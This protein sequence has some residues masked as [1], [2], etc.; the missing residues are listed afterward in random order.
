M[1]VTEILRG[2]GSWGVQLRQDTRQE[3]LDALTYFGHICINTGPVDPRTAGDAML[4]SARYVGIYRGRGNSGDQRTLIGP[5]LAAW[6]GDEDGKGEVFETGVVLNH[7]FQDAIPLLLPPGGSITAGTIFDVHPGSPFQWTARYI[8]PRE[9]IDYICQTVGADWRVNNNGTLDAGLESDLFTVV[10][11]AAIRRR[12]AGRD[13]FLKAMPG[14]LATDQDMN[15]FSTRVLLLA[16]GTEGSTVTATADIDPGLNPF[17][18]LHGNV[19]RMTRIVS[20]SS[21]DATN[22]DARAQL[23]LNRFSGPRTALTMSTKDYDVKGD[24]QVGDYLWAYDPDT[25]VYDLG[26][27]VVFR[28]ERFWPVALR[29]TEMTW[30]VVKGM[31]VAYRRGDGTWLDL[32]PYMKFEEGDTTLVVGGYNRNLGGDGGIAGGRPIPDTSIPAAPTWNETAFRYSVY[33]SP[34]DGNSKAQ[35][36]LNW[37]Q[38]LNVDGSIILDGDHYEIQYRTSAGPIFPATHD[39]MALRTHNQLALGTHDQPIVYAVSDVWETAFVPFDQLTY[40]LTNLATNMPYEAKIRAVDGAKP[41]NG[42]AWSTVALFQTSRDTIPPATPAPPSVAASKLAIQVTHDLGRSDGGTFNL[43]QDLHHLEVHGSTLSSFTPG[44]DTLLGKVIANAGMLLSN[45]PIVATFNI[46]NL[47]PVFFKV[48]AVD[49]DGNPSSP[50]SS[51]SATAELIDDAH[52]TNL[53]VSKITAGTISADWIIGAYIRT[54]VSPH[55]RVQLT[56]FGLEGYAEGNLSTFWVDSGSGNV[57]MKGQ[58]RSGDDDESRVIINPGQNSPRIMFYP[59]PGFGNHVEMKVVAYLD[60]RGASNTGVKI[61]SLDAFDNPIGGELEFGQTGVKMGHFNNGTN[62]WAYYWIDEQSRH[63]LRGTWNVS[64][65]DPFSA[66]VIGQTPYTSSGDG[67][68]IYS[69]GMTFA[70]A[71]RIVGTTE[72]DPGGTGTQYA[73]M[74]TSGA[75][76]TGFAANWV[77]NAGSS[78]APAASGK[79]YYWGF[80]T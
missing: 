46:D 19:I 45:T 50:S 27:E 79:M 75:H 76:T 80:R 24:F 28:G 53:T 33:Q 60:P 21:T 58:L 67:G 26:N 39:Q 61:A 18:D 51:V 10:P 17:V 54:G 41:P 69:Y 23:Q 63:A 49:Y 30:P 52:I 77:L 48:V 62:E 68:I 66:L 44:P 40:L 74:L 34:V 78:S 4:A 35:V 7:D 29:L 9:A 6:L 20:E 56:P 71:M 32:T 43:D 64:N 72:I 47:T 5:G 2:I 22:A 11:T 65:F 8:T 25:G 57:W 55:A 16:E 38:P 42:S 3:V 31:S 13:M 1:A 14:E 12:G 15:D 36:E 73:H 37:N 59:E 70:S